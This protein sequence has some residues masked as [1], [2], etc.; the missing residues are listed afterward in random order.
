M[1]SDEQFLTS[2]KERPCDWARIIAMVAGLTRF[3]SA[4]CNWDGFRRYGRMLDQFNSVSILA[5]LNITR[6][7]FIIFHVIHSS[8]YIPE[9]GFSKIHT[10]LSLYS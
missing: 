6:L 8:A 2:W 10:S 1:K 9:D 5:F 3:G 4:L 7:I